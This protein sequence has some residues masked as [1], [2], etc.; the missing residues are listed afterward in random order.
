[1]GSCKNLKNILAILLLSLGAAGVIRASDKLYSYSTKR[2]TLLHPVYRTEQL[3]KA[4]THFD[5]NIK[6]MNE[7]N[8]PIKKFN[9]DWSNVKTEVSK[10]KNEPLL[11]NFFDPNDE[12]SNLENVYKRINYF[13]DD[14]NQE[15]KSSKK[16]KERIDL[17]GFLDNAKNLKEDFNNL[18]NSFDI[19]LK[20]IAEEGEEESSNSGK[21]PVQT[22]TFQ[23]IFIDLKERAVKHLERLRTAVYIN[24]EIQKLNERLT[25]AKDRYSRVAVK[26]SKEISLLLEKL[27]NASK[28]ISQLNTNLDKKS[29]PSEGEMV[30]DD[31]GYTKKAIETLTKLGYTKN[32]HPNAKDSSSFESSPRKFHKAKGL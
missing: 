2:E 27:S 17:D 10:L 23:N 12:K 16:R 21:K 3:S 28:I 15:D 6:D 18:M 14:I 26:N 31:D 24:D 11:V 22:A 19:V 1:M 20:T 13:V 4:F 5:K 25:K 30:S 7:G 8:T 32:I 9:Y 29:F